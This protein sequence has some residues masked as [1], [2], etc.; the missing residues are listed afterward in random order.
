MNCTGS[1]SNCGLIKGKSGTCLE[2]TKG[3]HRSLSVDSWC[4]GW[5]PN[6]TAL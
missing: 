5:N 6:Q 1:R 4:Y 3:T 2:G